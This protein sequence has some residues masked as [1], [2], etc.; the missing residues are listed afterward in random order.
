MKR[1]LKLLLSLFLWLILAGL[2]YYAVLYITCPVYKFANPAPFRGEKLY[3][4]YQDMNP[5]QWKKAN[6]QVQ[7]RAW[8]GITDG[9]KNTNEE[10]ERVYKSLGYDIIATSDYQKI[11]MYKSNEPS[12]LPVYEHG[13]NIRKVHQVLIGS[14]RVLWRDF[15][16]FQNIHNKQRTLN[17]LRK[18]N[19]VIVIAHP[20]FEK[21]YKPENMKYLANYDAIEA[22]N[23]FRRSFE[24]W[25]TALSSGNFVT[26][27]GNDDVHDITNPDEVGQYMTFINA[28]VVNRKNVTET[29]RKGNTFGAYVYRPVGES[30]ETKME[31]AKRIPVLEEVKIY[32]KSI[33]VRV[34]DTASRIVFI[35]QDGRQRAYSNNTPF[36]S[37]LFKEEDSY[38]RTEIHFG[39]E[40]AF[41][42]NPVCRYAGDFPARINPPEINHYKTWL[43]RIVGFATLF[44]ILFNIFFFRRK[45]RRK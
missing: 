42:L 6:F 33:F 26:I 35:G 44:F 28:P 12:F 4:P 15:P 14:D 30:M 32:G 9:R 21:G 27:I 13:Y 25:D 34:S 45:L 22:L 8:G 39:E 36:A 7:S 5:S 29:I 1:I 10:I 19:D 2:V 23:Y 41:Y 40:M 20:N 37:Y 38:I 18:D 3:N 24:H 17:L 31:K 16:F 11:N 43:L